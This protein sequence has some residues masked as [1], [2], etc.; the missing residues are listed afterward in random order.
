MYITKSSSIELAAFREG[1]RTALV[2]IG[3]LRVV[4]YSAKFVFAA[5]RVSPNRA[6]ERDGSSIAPRWRRRECGPC[7]SYR[8]ELFL[9]AGWIAFDIC[10]RR[11]STGHII[12]HIC[13]GGPQPFHG[14][15]L[16]RVAKT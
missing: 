7:S 2:H 3:E 4:L 16:V 14:T 13:Q 1:Y 10:A 11:E 5:E 9:A 8:T 12:V 6:A 15:E